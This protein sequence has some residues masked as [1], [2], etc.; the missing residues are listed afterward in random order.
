MI[1]FNLDSYGGKENILDKFYSFKVINGSQ[2]VLRL[3]IMSMIFDSHD[4][5]IELPDH[6]FETF[7]ETIKNGVFK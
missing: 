1:T 5:C 7:S 6:L 2:E 4:G 3:K